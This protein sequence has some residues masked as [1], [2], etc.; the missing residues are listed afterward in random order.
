[1]TFQP[2]IFAQLMQLLDHDEIKRCIDRYEGNKRVRSF[3]C[4]E[5]FLCMAFSQLAQKKS[6]RATVFSLENM[7]HKLYHM[8]IRGTVSLNA[9]SDA[10]NVRNWRIWRDYAKSLISKA[11]ELYQDEPVQVDEEIATSVYAFDSSTVDLCLSLF[12]WA[13]F[14]SA[15]AGI[16]LH[17]QLDLRGFI[18]RF[19]STSPKPWATM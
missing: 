5:Q 15:K 2:T 1:M 14:R 13:N 17:T 4:L 12:P 9:L 7:Q 8:G 11:R 18:P 3:S 16:K 19:T 6:M 10:N